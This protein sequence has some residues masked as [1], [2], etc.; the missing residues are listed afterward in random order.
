[1]PGPHTRKAMSL[2][3]IILLLAVIALLLFAVEALLTPGFGVA[4]V[5]AALCVVA[6]DV[7]TYIEY[8]GAATVAAVLVSV[9]VVLLFLRWLARSKTLDRAALR[10]TIASSAPTA[11]QLSVRPGDEGTALTRLALIGNAEIGGKTVEVKSTG[12]FIDEGTPIVVTAVSEALIL[13][14][15][16]QKQD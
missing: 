8:G 9:V 1:M 11:E 16:K 12:G 14:R 2:T 3:L 10:A 7:L 4:G 15:P 13:V 5:L 6:A